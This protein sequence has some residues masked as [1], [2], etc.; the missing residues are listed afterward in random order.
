MQQPLGRA[1]R[2]HHLPWDNFSISAA[3][4]RPPPGDAVCVP[5][6][7]YAR[8]AAACFSRAAG[9]NVTARIRSVCDWC[10]VGRPPN[11]SGNVVRMSS[12]GSGIVRQSG[13]DESDAEKK[14][15]PDVSWRSWT[16]RVSRR[17][18]KKTA[19]GH[20]ANTRV[21]VFAIA[22]GATLRFVARLGPG[23]VIAA[24]SVPKRCGACSIVS[25]NG[26]VATRT[27][28]ASSDNWNINRRAADEPVSPLLLP[29][30]DRL[31]GVDGPSLGPQL[32]VFLSVMATLSVLPEA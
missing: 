8:D 7:V 17:R 19:R 6:S 28:V 30:P 27:R 10:A 5:E 9:T 32:F 29:S 18:G 14:R 3:S 4:R 15:P 20:A 31:R 24:R 25:V 12:T 26:C 16:G 11:V 22:R 23:R 13:S 1:P 21:E 2:E